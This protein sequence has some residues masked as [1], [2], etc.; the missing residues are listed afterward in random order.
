MLAFREGNTLFHRLD[1]ITKFTWCFI[2]TFWL[3]SLTDFPTMVFGCLGLFLVALIG[4]RLNL[5]RYAKSLVLISI[6]TPWIILFQ[7]WSR[8]GPGIELGP[9]HLSQEGL[10]IGVVLA[11]RTVGLVACSLA[12]AQTTQAKDI[13]L[14]LRKVGVPFKYAYLIYISLRFLPLM[15]ADLQSLNDVYTLRGVKG[16]E[17][18]RQTMVALLATEMR[19]VDDTTIAL[20][21]R[22]FGLHKNPTQIEKI[23]LTR[24][25]LVLIG[26]TLII[27]I[28]SI[29]VKGR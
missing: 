15:E 1:P 24:S 8:P 29:F 27:I 20:E 13:V 4:A 18:T 28:G 12:L 19:R 16:W 6:G 7:G 14:T 21:T 25:G 5:L 3:F 23:T 9:F 26:V 22:A 10:Q 11:L 2:T 17:K